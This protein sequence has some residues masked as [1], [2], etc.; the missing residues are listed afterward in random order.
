MKTNVKSNFEILILQRG[1]YWKYIKRPMDFI[2]SFIAIILLSPILLM[3]SILVKVNLGSPIIFK[4]ERPGINEN[5]FTMYKFRTMTNE[6]DE[7]GTFLSDNIR[8]TK[9]GKF[10]RS[11]SIDE[12]PQLFNILKGDMSIVGPRPHI[13]KDVVFMDTEQRMRHR[14]LPGLTGLAQVRGRNCI[15]WQEKL[16]LDLEYIE[17]VSFINDWKIMFLTVIMVVKRSCIAPKG[18]VTGECLGD[19]LLRTDKITDEKYNGTINSL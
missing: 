5:M 16:R 3:V 14:V 8:L 2:L 12:L 19:Y 4:Q 7:S 6:R 9:F 1:I 18:M 10:L 13:V 15:D 11:T 17:K